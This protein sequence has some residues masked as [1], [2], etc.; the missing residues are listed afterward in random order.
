MFEDRTRY[1]FNKGF[2]EAFSVGEVSYALTLLWDVHELYLLG[3]DLALDADTKQTHAEGHESAKDQNNL[4]DIQ[5]NDSV[6]LRESELY[7]K[8]NFIDKVPTTPLFDMSRIMVDTFTKRY[9]QEYQKVYNL[10]NGAYFINTVAKKSDGIDLSKTNKVKNAKLTAE[11]EEFCNTHASASM[12][13]DEK[14]ALHKRVKD[15][16]NKKELIVNFANQKSPSIGQ[17]QSSFNN[18][19]GQLIVTSSEKFNELAQIY[20]IYLENIGGYIGDFFNTSNINNPKRN[21]KHFQKIIATQF[22]K[23]VDKYLEGLKETEV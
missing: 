23:I 14:E 20:I 6:S 1:R 10:N 12:D 17:F 9:K 11:I 19:A 16:L 2:I 7:V 22:L 18:T 15:A 13:K 3:L 21:I 4:V 8:G 5:E